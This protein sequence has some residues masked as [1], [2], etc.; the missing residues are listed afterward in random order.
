MPV[1]TIDNRGLIS[2]AGEDAEDLLQN[3]ITTDLSLV[4]AGEAWPGALLTPQ[5]KILVEFLIGRTDAGFLMETAAADTDAL[6]KRLT[7]YRLRAK[8]TFE[9]LETGEVALIWDEAQPEAGLSDQRFARAGIMLKRVPGHGGT[10]AISLYRA[11][12]MANGISGGGEDGP[13]GD[14]FPHDLM[15]DKNGGLSFKKGCYIGQEVVSRMQHRS[16]ARRRL[17]AVSA[18]YALAEPGAPL[19]AG[20]REIGTLIAT[21]GNK[22]LA[23]VRID[24]AGS[25]MAAGA[26]ITLAEQNVT[27]VLPV[28]C[29]L[30]FPTDMD[31]AAS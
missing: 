10:E 30:G 14:Y 20:G 6:I 13:L 2:I 11:L 8:V 21:E 18:E 1:V 9:K 5:G 28:W 26:A 3:I 19:L 25:A 24:K 16:T 17:A 7:L 15:M 27:L 22:G 29:G 23:V 31:E 4:A 12:R